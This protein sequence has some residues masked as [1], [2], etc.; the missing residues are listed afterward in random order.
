MNPEPMMEID[1]TTDDAEVQRR[2]QIRDEQI[3]IIFGL[4]DLIVSK[5]PEASKPIIESDNDV[6]INIDLSNQ[7]SGVLATLF[8]CMR[9]AD[10]KNKS[11]TAAI[12]ELYEATI[13]NTKIKIKDLMTEASTM[14][15][16]PDFIVATPIMNLYTIFK[17]SF[18]EVSMGVTR[19]PVRDERGTSGIKR[20]ASQSESTSARQP[21]AK[22]RQPT[23][24]LSE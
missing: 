17:C 9:K 12:Y 19:F 22:P 1:T 16:T 23:R 24:N 13:D 6:V 2:L 20:T 21:T 15:L 10:P 7:I 8:T 3:D 14:G 11:G 4:Y 18:D 5:L